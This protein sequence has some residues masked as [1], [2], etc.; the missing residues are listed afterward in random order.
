MSLTS[1]RAAPPRAEGWEGTT[2]WGQ[3]QVRSRGKENAPDACSGALG[4]GLGPS[5]FLVLCREE[6]FRALQAWRRP[7]LPC[8]ET[9][10][11]WR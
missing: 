1:Y 6:E 11:H 7:T 9:K 4:L 2:A 5:C 10:Y 3:R 8:L